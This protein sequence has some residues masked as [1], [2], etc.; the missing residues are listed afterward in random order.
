MYEVEW[1]EELFQSLIGQ[2][3]TKFKISSIID[4]AGVSIPYR[5]AK[6]PFFEKKGGNKNEVSIPYR[7]A[8][9]GTDSVAFSWYE[10]QFQS[11]IG[12]LK[13]SSDIDS[14]VNTATRF[15]PL[16]VS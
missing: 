13:T 11:L 7:L 1:I 2:L 15:N 4:L 3:K 8:K 9:N 5:L 14:P 12:Q 6:N 10:Y 16:Q